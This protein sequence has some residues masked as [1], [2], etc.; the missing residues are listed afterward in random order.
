[1]FF[2]T[3]CSRCSLT[4]ESQPNRT[5]KSIY[6]KVPETAFNSDSIAR[7][8]A[9]LHQEENLVNALSVHLQNSNYLKKKSIILKKVRRRDQLYVM[10]ENECIVYLGQIQMS[11]PSKTSRNYTST[12]SPFLHFVK[13]IFS[14]KANLYPTSFQQGLLNVRNLYFLIC[15]FKIIIYFYI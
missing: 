10:F 3:T 6:T 8:L 11:F 7:I 1:M 2:F 5:M 9:H 15:I 12:L 4:F 14:I 13:M